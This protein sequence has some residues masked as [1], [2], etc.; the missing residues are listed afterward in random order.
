MQGFGLINRLTL[1]SLGSAPAPWGAIATALILALGGLIVALR[2][3]YTTA[4][5]LNTNMTAIRMNEHE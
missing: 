5:A 1:G 4:A 3:W 2:A